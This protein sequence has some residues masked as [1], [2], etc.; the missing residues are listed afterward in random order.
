MEPGLDHQGGMFVSLKTSHD[1]HLSKDELKDLLL[2]LPVH[3]AFYVA[4]PHY[5]C[6]Y[7]ETEH[8]IKR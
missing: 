3:P 2:L 5:F 7:L 6:L 4:C 1:Q 8:N